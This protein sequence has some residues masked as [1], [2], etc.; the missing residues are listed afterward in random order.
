MRLP[1]L[2]ALALCFAIVFAAQS[3]AHLDY[4]GK[5]APRLGQAR[6]RLQ[7]MFAGPRTVAHRH[8]RRS[9]E[10]SAKADRIP[11]HRRPGHAGEQRPY[12]R[13]SRR[14]RQLH[15]GRRRA[16]RSGSVSLPPS[17]RRA[18]Q[19]QAHRH[20]RPPGAQERRRKAGRRGH[21]AHRRRRQRRTPCWQ[22]FGRTC[23]RQPAPAKR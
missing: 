22:R 18:G 6:P 2:A 4:E 19:G 20:G 5:R 11:L 12:H 7:G 9:F 1:A 14:P 13:G 21:A 17:R 16:L 10:Q 3:A 8:S 23:P 15:R